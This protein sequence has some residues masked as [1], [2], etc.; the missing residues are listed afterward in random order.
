MLSQILS[1]PYST[2]PALSAATL[3]R[4]TSALKSYLKNLS[5]ETSRPFVSVAAEKWNRKKKVRA[6]DQRKGQ[7]GTPDSL[8][9]HLFCKLKIMKSL[10]KEVTSFNCPANKPEKC[11]VKSIFKK[12]HLFSKCTNYKKKKDR[13]RILSK[14]IT[15]KYWSMNNF[16]TNLWI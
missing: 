12:A 11:T 4:E 8:C 7:V 15:E 10:A 14:L 2:K 16:F 3:P 1:V 13:C 9:F 5:K 6:C